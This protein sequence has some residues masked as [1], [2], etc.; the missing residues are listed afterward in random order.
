MANVRD[1]I[2]KG[3]NTRGEKTKH[4][5]LNPEKIEQIYAMRRQGLTQREIAERF[6]ITR[7]HVGQIL[8]ANRWRHIKRKRADTAEL[9]RRIIRR[10]S[11]KG[12]RHGRS[13][14]AEAQV[15]EIKRRLAEGF[16][17]DLLAQEYGVS[18]ATVSLIASGKRWSHL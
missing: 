2:R 17:Q 5:V 12:D 6:D 4:A 8:T 7:G 13:K 1:C 10:V 11:L 16:R 9:K 15:V 3:R 14:L 18:K